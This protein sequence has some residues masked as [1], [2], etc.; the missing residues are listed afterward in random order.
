[1]SAHVGRSDR[2]HSQ[3]HSTALLD[4]LALRV[5]VCTLT[6]SKN[7]GLRPPTTSP[8][9]PPPSP[10]PPSLLP[11][12]HAVRD[13]AGLACFTSVLNDGSDDDD[14]DDNEDDEDDE[15]E[16]EEPEEVPEHKR[17]KRAR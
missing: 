9:L 14:D 10:L 4:S 12:N 7:E 17:A 15:K 1:M 8:S 2:P 11:L 13:D 3:K 5:H 6:S 16:E